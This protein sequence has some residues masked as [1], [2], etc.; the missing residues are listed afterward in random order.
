MNPLLIEIHALNLGLTSR[1]WGTFNQWHDLGCRVRKR[2]GN[3]EPGRW[4]CQVVFWKPLT[5]TVVDDQT[6]EEEDEKRFVLRTFTVFSADQVEG[7]RASEFQVHE[8][9]GQP[10]SRTRLR[11]RRALLA[12]DI[13][14][15]GWVSPCR[16]CLGV[17][18]YS[19][20]SEGC[21]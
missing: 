1:F 17:A 2:P 19:W 10:R 6:G 14:G 20:E 15:S 18:W 21:L 13:R 3:V 12:Q 5:K 4:G 16:R 8:E 7:D 11:P 9:A